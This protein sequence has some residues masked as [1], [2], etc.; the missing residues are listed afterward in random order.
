MTVEFY[1]MLFLMIMWFLSFVDVV[2][3]ID[4]HTL[5]HP[6]ELGM[7]P[8]LLWYVIFFMYCLIQFDDILHQRYWSV[9]FFFFVVSLSG[10]DIRW[11]RRMSLGVFPSLSLLEDL[12][13]ISISSFMFGRIHLG[14]H[15]VLDF[16]L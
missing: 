1:Q 9:I 10:F 16:C 3:Y 5:N 2:Y 6:C 4:L 13:R 14:S 8:T 11:L 7:N 12:R 15:L